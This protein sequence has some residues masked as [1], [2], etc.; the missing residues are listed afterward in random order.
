MNY[1]FSV[2]NWGM[3]KKSKRAFRPAMNLLS[4]EVSGIGC[5]LM[6]MTATATQKTIRIL[7]NQLPEISNWVNYLS[8]PVRDNVVMVVPPP[9]KLSAKVETLIE[10][11][12][13]DMK[14]NGTTYLFLVRSINKGTE[15]F[16]HLLKSLH[17]PSSKIRN[18]VF[19]HR[20]TTESRKEFILNDLKLP[21][22]SAEKTIQCVIATVSLGKLFLSVRPYKGD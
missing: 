14:V 1:F 15:V 3:D 6:L 5:K 20:N 9:E 10:P 2:A 19:F 12:V 16:L 22:G 8:L 13:Q 4:G 11:F 21:L 7:Q 18:V 17:D